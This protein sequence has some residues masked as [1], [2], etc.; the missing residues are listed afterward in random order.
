[1][2]T[3][4]QAESLFHEIE[5]LIK[6][7]SDCKQLSNT[8]E[9]RLRDSL[10]KYWEIECPENGKFC[11]PNRCSYKNLEAWTEPYGYE[12][13]AE[14]LHYFEY[15]DGKILKI[16]KKKSIDIMD[17]HWRRRSGHYSP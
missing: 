2:E 15:T 10:D 8:E 13:M 7:L 5:K 6:K 14:L 9:K 11:L 1:M 12:N 4:C 16:K 17:A 3:L